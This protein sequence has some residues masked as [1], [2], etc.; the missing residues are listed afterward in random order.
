MTRNYC[1]TGEYVRE[2]DGGIW[3]VDG[4]GEVIE[5]GLALNLL[6]SDET[7]KSRLKIRVGFARTSPEPHLGYCSGHGVIVT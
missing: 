3:V 4:R 5:E 2:S 6:G 1:R 7:W